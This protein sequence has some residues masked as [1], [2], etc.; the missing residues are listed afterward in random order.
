M[1]TYSDD[2]NLF[3]ATNND[4]HKKVAR[5]IDKAARD[6]IAEDPGT[7][8]HAAR[9]LW[10]NAVRSDVDGLITKAHAAILLVLD[11]PTVAAAGNAASDSDVQFVVNSLVNTLADQ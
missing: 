8:N 1:V 4:L 5:A 7:A 6:V 2:F 3:S 9:L 10:A 11:N